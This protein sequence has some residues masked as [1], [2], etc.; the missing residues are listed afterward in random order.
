MAG[1][2]CHTATCSGHTAE[3]H[4][5]TAKPFH[6]TAGLPCH[7]ATAPDHAAGSIRHA[8]KPFC[9]AGKSFH[10]AAQSF[11]RTV[12]R[13]NHAKRA[14]NDLPAS[15]ASPAPDPRPIIKPMKIKT[16]F[17]KLAAI[18]ALTGSIH[19][20]CGQA[21]GGPGT[22]ASPGAQ[23]GPY[24]DSTG[25]T[26]EGNNP[27]GADGAVL[28]RFETGGTTDGYTLGDIQLLFADA[29]GTP[30]DDMVLQLRMDSSGNEGDIITAFTSN[31]QPTTAGLYTYVPQADTTLAPNTAYWISASDRDHNEANYEWSYTGAINQNDG[32]S[33]ST[34]ENGT[35][36]PVFALNATPIEPAPEPSSFALIVLGAMGL[37]YFRR[38]ARTI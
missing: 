15:I 30:A 13:K 23:P 22:P 16:T 1:F 34:I 29:N 6:R 12:F 19:S 5:R 10:R 25:M 24:L 37:L 7:T 26:L 11:H 18:L 14:K 9:H 33:I 38:S 36:I 20:A 31:P 17:T 27:V 8:G 3:S 4:D 28:F 35:G 32:W 21:T 2:R